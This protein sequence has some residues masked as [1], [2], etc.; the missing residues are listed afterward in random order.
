[1]GTGAFRYGR[2]ACLA[3][4]R[5]IRLRPALADCSSRPNCGKSKK[6]ESA[7]P[8]WMFGGLVRPDG[9]LCT[10]WSADC[11]AAKLGLIVIRAGGATSILMES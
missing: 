4:S 11:A 10:A 9:A 1:M 3:T 7:S 2:R 8:V 5:S 6:T